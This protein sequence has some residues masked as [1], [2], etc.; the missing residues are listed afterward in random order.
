M[1]HMRV[2]SQSLYRRILFTTTGIAVL[3]TGLV[4]VRSA[5]ASSLPC[6]ILS[7]A[8]T[9]C[10]AAYSTTRALYAAYSGSLYKVTRQSDNTTKNI[11]LLSTGGYANAATQDTFCANT[12]CT[13]TEIYDQSSNANN[14][15]PAP[16]GGEASGPGPNGY[17]LPAFASAYPVSA[18][19][20]K[21]Y[22]IY[23]QS[24]GMGYRDD[25]TK[26]IATNGEP[27]GVYEV[28]SGLTN[29]AGC[30]ADFGN[31]ETNN[32]DNGA[33]HMDA[34]ALYCA[35][36][37]C[38]P[39]VNIDMENGGYGDLAVTGGTEFV[40]AM[41]SNDGQKHYAVYQGNAQ[42][43]SIT[44]TGTLT[45][46]SG[47]SPM[48]QEGGV[49]L[50]VGGDNSL[51]ST[52]S[53]F[54]GVMTSGA[55]TSAT[56]SSIQAN[57]V[58]V[59]YAGLLPYHDGFGS[60]SASG[61][62]TYNGTWSVSSSSYVNSANDGNGDKAVTGSATWDNYTLQGDVEMTASGGNAGLILR[63][64]NPAAG[65]DSLDGYYVGVDSSNSALVLGRES[66][67]WTQ[68][69]TVAMS[70]GV[71]AN[72]WYHLTVQAVGCTFTVSAQPA[73]STTVTGFTYTDS[74]CTFTA[75]AIGVRSFYTPAEWHNISVTV[76]GSSTLPYYAP[77]AASS[78]PSGWTTYAGS[79]SLSGGNYIDSAID[80]SGDKSIGGPTSGNFT[81]TGDV[82][83]TTS[84]GNA[85]FLVRATNP[86]VGAD[87]VDGYF[88]GVDS[89]GQIVIGEE[90]YG[91]NVLAAAPLV[92]AP[93]DAWYHLTGQVVGCQL[94][95]TA[96]PINKSTPVSDVI[97]TDCTFS[98]G[99]TGVRA[100]DTSAE[101]R[102]LSVIPN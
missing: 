40:T 76:G 88:L 73:G 41:L 14:L 35:G 96:Q 80:T 7:A 49:V 91:W 90:S 59:G 92:S 44:T 51:T 69:H 17:D 72:V 13:I 29:N 25:A 23:I 32:D 3:V 47:Y 83:I 77:F 36:T 81:L 10:V 71:S 33:G 63:V 21:V 45:L 46:A 86:G 31:A 16:P 48:H 60:G 55:P 53:F 84:G 54:E 50:G 18:G 8:S 52:G 4:D 38:S 1:M 97:V 98:S 66:Y 24:G 64:T 61:W 101:W 56:M 30:C 27:E 93:S 95:L 19:G 26:G 5:Q 34:L 78:G 74:G 62:T 70:G 75:G 11:G 87:S 43:G 15:T 57:I 79:W 68:L 28:V 85:G 42:S 89:S 2:K 20:H 94:R 99:Q 22:G 67:G 39:F 37:P 102:D 12:I 100:Y 82:D 6:D 58:S 65:T 9:P